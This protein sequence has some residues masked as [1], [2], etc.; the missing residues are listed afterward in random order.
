MVFTVID[1]ILG[2]A[3]NIK[4]M[5]SPWSLFGHLRNEGFSEREAANLNWMINYRMSGELLGAT[6]GLCTVIYQDKFI[7]NW[8]YR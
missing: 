4:Q 8:C 3:P 6:L 5:E 7:R 2:G 1:R